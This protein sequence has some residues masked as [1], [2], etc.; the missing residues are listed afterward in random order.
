MPAIQA[1]TDMKRIALILTLAVL[2]GCTGGGHW[3]SAEKSLIGE[4]S[5]GMRVLTVDDRSDSLILRR[6]CSD[7]PVSDLMGETYRVLAQSLIETVTSP[8]QDGVGIA[9]PQAGLSRRVVAVM[10]YDKEGRPFEVF[11]NIR[12][13]GTYGDM[14]PGPE[15]C[16][17]VPGKRGRVQRYKDIEISYTSPSSLKDTVERVSG[18]TAVIFQHECDHLDGVI[19][20]DKLA[21]E[22]MPGDFV[23]VTDVIPDA[24]LEIRY[25]TTF[26]FIGDRIPGYEAPVAIMTRRAADSLKAVSDELR[27]KGFRLKIFDA[28]RPQRAVDYFVRWAEDIG[29]VRMKEF[30]YPELDKAVLIPQEYIAPKSSHTRGSTVDLTLFDEKLQRE[31]DM[32]CTF[33]YFGEA[34]HPDIQ[35][36]QK[37]GAYRPISKSQYEDR[38]IL[39]EA[40]LSHG[41]NPY[42]CEWWH[43]T[44][45]DEPY[46]DTYFDFP[47][48]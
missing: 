24:I 32:G 10:R 35:P 47:V 17:S 38:M 29:D 12:I 21:D 6:R 23:K 13:T 37:A 25:H 5:H 34:S 43:F 44:L 40:M 26:N 33:D 39:R 30:F 48:K 15:G 20:T 2:T 45:A 14:E 11:P 1:L 42:E 4:E 31:V 46:P 22:S 28:Y 7:I 41:F 36:G 16:L 9:G 27:S 8:E 18:Y 3:T 19:Y